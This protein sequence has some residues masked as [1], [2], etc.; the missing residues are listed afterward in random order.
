MSRLPLAPVAVVLAVLVAACGSG[1]S[2]ERSVPLRPASLTCP[3]HPLP[4]DRLGFRNRN[5]PESEEIVPGDPGQL[6][7]CRYPGSPR[8]RRGPVLAA[9]RYLREPA[10]VDSIAR[11]LNDLPPAKGAYACPADFGATIQALFHYESGA[12]ALVAVRLGGCPA[13]LNGSAHARDLTVHA[14]NRLKRLVPLDRETAP[15]AA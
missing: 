9:H 4:E 14:E 2:A 3:R 1:A 13:V 10:L 12:T 7:L 6:M 11:R 5:L 8:G 15:A